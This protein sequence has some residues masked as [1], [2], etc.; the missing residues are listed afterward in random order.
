MSAITRSLRMRDIHERK[1][2]RGRHH[3]LD[4]TGSKELASYSRGLGL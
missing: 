3:V 4:H 1:R 2:L